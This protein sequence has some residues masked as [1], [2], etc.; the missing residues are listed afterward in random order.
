MTRV[1]TTSTYNLYLSQM[2]KQ[3]ASM[4]DYSYQ[5]TTG[6]RYSSYDKY[7]LFS[8]RLITLQNEQN[9]T[10]KYLETNSITQ[11]M[12]DSQQTAMEG[13]RTALSD[14]RSQV[15]EL[16]SGILTD[17]SE[18]FSEEELSILRNTQEAAFDTMSLISY[19]L[20]TQVDGNYIF[21][22]GETTVKPV[23]FPYTT[24]SEFQSVYDGEFLTYPTS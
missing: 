10:S 22:G 21:G 9:I 6:H 4:T 1:P 14:I 8:Y 2:T 7:G 20:N 19:Y 18:G 16:Y 24:L 17:S 15:R 12:L 23:D 13:I 5:S 11:I 3:K